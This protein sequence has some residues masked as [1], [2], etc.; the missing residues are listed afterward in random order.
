MPA[1]KNLLEATAA[2]NNR[3]AM[4]NALHF[5]QKNMEALVG[6]NTSYVDS[7]ELEK[8]HMELFTSSIALFHKLEKFGGLKYSEPYLKELKNSIE[9]A[10]TFLKN[11]NDY[12]KA[13]SFNRLALA[14]TDFKSSINYWRSK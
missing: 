14:W 6:G 7:K 11:E 3:E 5:Y 4:A 8:K 1:I 12:K 2:A 13:W 10:W 9:E